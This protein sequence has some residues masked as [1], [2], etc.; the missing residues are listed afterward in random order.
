[1]K[2]LAVVLST[3]TAIGCATPA[4]P[5]NVTIAPDP[6][7]FGSVY[8][9][10]TSPKSATLTNASGNAITVRASSLG[11]G[12]VFAIGTAAPTLPAGVPNNGTLSFPFTFTP[13]SKG[14]QQGSWNLTLDKRPYAIDLKGEGVL[15]TTDGEFVTGGPTAGDGLNFGDVVVGQTK[16]LEIQLRNISLTGT[17]YVFPAAPA[18]APATPF[19]VS[20]PNAGYTL[21]APPNKSMVKIKV[22]F[23]PT[24]VG[25]FTA[26]LTWP[27]N[28]KVVRIKCFL[29]GNGIA[30]GPQ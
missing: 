2:I 1:M 11:P 25:H 16:E 5:D 6:V 14:P 17:V 10:D 4:L 7:D 21:N 22:V 26:T 9:G 3:I 8:V 20:S 30:A 23:A 24:A 13:P 12:T 29:Q 15:F 19:T 27:D 18:V 28:P